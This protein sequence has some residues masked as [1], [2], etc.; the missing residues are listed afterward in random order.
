MGERLTMSAQMQR[1]G[2][3]LDARFSRHPKSP[4]VWNLL[5]RLPCPAALVL[6]VSLPAVASAQDG[7]IPTV[8]LSTEHSALCR[9]RVGDAFPLESLPNL[10]GEEQQLAKLRGTRATVIL[11]WHPDLYMSRAALADLQTDVAEKFPREEVALW[12]IA[13]KSEPAEVERLAAESNAEFPQLLDADG[14]AFRQL[15]MVK[16]PRLYVIDE[17][18]EDA[19]GKIVWFDLEY[20]ESTRRELRWTLEALT[21]GAEEK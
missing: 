6:L 11:V 15:G 18:T 7:K 16:L 10:Q 8:Y 1:S 21:D 12:G 9:V 20:S 13:V 19:P 14:A 3:S 17:S 5:V 2:S 4:D